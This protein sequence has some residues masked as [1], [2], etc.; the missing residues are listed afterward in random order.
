MTPERS[1]KMPPIAAKA[2]GVAKRIVAAKRPAF[3]T[4]S[5]E[6]VSFV[7]AQSAAA[8]PPIATATAHQPSRFSSRETA[9][10][11][12]ARPAM[13]TAI[14]PPSKR[15]SHGGSASQKASEAEPDAVPGDRLRLGEPAEPA[16]VLNG[17]RDRHQSS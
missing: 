1:Q 6:S 15:T 3:T 2:S 9:Q 14:G 17:S 11:P 5:S 12:A 4:A 13:P 16:V 8:V 7:C 10:I